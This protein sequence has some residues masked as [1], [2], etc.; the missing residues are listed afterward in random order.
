MLQITGESS[1]KGKAHLY[2]AIAICVGLIFGTLKLALAQSTEDLIPNTD[3]TEADAVEGLQLPMH[4]VGSIFSGASGLE[5]PSMDIPILPEPSLITF[6]LSKSQLSQ[7]EQAWIQRAMREGKEP[8]YYVKIASQ[9]KAQKELVSRI[10][11]D[12]V[13]CGSG[14][15]IYPDSQICNKFGSH[16]EA[17][18]NYYHCSLNNYQL[19]L[20]NGELEAKCGHGAPSASTCVDQGSIGSGNGLWKPEADPKAKCKG[21][22]T[23]LLDQKYEAVTQIQILD[24]NKEFVLEPA[25]FGKLSDGRPRFCAEGRPGS[26]FNPGPIYIKYNS[27]GINE[28]RSVRDPSKREE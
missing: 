13:M 17:E 28:C 2:L 16:V 19:A 14:F 26:S 8:L 7:L 23:I 12:Q 9:E 4:D 11:R 24:S 10:A 6:P 27:N 21:G 20:R 3:V 18:Q 1:M 25:Y 22:T 15:E 5:S